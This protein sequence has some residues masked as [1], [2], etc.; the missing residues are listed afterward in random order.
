M[1]SISKKTKKGFTLVEL[2]VVVAILGILAAITI[3]RFSQY[4]AEAKWQQVNSNAM[5]VYRAMCAVETELIAEGKL[6]L[7][8]SGNSTEINKEFYERVS[9]LIPSD[10]VIARA[11]VPS[12]PYDEN[13]MKNFYIDYA[14]PT[15][16]GNK[17][18]MTVSIVLSEWKDPNSGASQ[19]W[20][21]F[22]WT[23]GEYTSLDKPF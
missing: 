3:P 20:K 9:K 18:T 6:D 19:Y 16:T 15:G 17:G 8:S 14:L 23:N 13:D 11:S 12:D 21:Y 1:K 10:I 7:T 4:V 5:T 22:T 2:I